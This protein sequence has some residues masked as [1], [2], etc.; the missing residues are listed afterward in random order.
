MQPKPDKRRASLI[1]GAV[2]GVLTGIPGINII[3]ICC[4]CAGLMAGGAIAYYVYRS[5]HQEGMEPLES[6]DG[7]VLGIFSGL[8]GAVAGTLLS[9]VFGWI[10]GHPDAKLVLKF[11]DWLESKGSL[12]PE[13]VDQLDQ[14]REEMQR[15]IERGPTVG[16][17][18]QGLFFSLILNPIFS[19][20]G[21]L[22]A[23]G[24]FGK[25]KYPEQ[26]IQPQ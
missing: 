2:I 23:Y 7:V 26:T 8:I 3:A 11:F 19:M 4:C 24:L 12:P 6:A 5:E 15:Q 18:F 20:F 16:K 9:L 13:T 21:G 14:L 17:I 25:K 10:L 1:G 22:I